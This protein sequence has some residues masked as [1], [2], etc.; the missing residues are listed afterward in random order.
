MFLWESLRFKDGMKEK[1]MRKKIL[2]GIED[3][4]EHLT[5]NA[6]VGKGIRNSLILLVDYIEYMMT[7]AEDD[8]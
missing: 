6:E 7:P 8:D 4:R 1:E 3:C 5:E 2:D